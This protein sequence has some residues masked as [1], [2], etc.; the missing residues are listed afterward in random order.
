[1]GWRE[2][3]TGRA[4]EASSPPAV[5]DAA[6]D[7][8]AVL[9]RV[10]DSA[11][12]VRRN[13]G[14]APFDVDGRDR[15]VAERAEMLDRLGIVTFPSGLPDEALGEIRD[16]LFRFASDV[17]A[18]R[19]PEGVAGFR[20]S[21]E[22]DDYGTMAASETAVVSVR[23]DDGV[24]A[25]MIDIFNVDRLLPGVGPALREAML[26]V[27]TIELLELATGA[28]VEDRNLNAYI[29]ESVTAT[30][31][32][33]VDSY[34]RK[35]FKVFVYL[36]DVL[37]LDDGPYCYAPTSHRLE[38]MEEANRR[39]A[40]AFGLSKTDVRL[41][42]PELPLPLLAPRGTIIVSDQGGAHRGFPQI[43]GSRR[44]LGVLNCRIVQ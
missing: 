16:L 23:G 35:Q 31:G 13:A 4:H 8:V 36:T 28:K 22:D 17:R 1:M 33:H 5:R 2:R 3:M 42:P 18:G 39:L 12:W 30:R 27:G 14:A 44:I 6:G 43:P 25:G 26:S 37:S 20:R 10:A 7:A 11:D 34:S 32:L 38:G 29:N 15:T 41:C 21:G 24:D 19:T 40:D 9:D